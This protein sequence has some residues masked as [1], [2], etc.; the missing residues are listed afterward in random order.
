MRLWKNIRRGWGSF[1]VISDLR[2]EMAPTLD[3]GMIC[4]VGIWLLRKPFQVYMALFVRKMLVLRSF[5]VF[6]WLQ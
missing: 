4:G 6:G 3:F 2:C 1:I 5:G